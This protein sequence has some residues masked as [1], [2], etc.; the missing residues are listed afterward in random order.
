MGRVTH[1]DVKGI[2]YN[3]SGYGRCDL[4][5]VVRV[6]FYEFPDRPGRAL[7]PHCIEAVAP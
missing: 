5:G 2:R 6:L 7:C 3:R 1:I 4:C